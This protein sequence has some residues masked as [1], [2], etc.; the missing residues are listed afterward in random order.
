MTVL[1]QNDVTRLQ[2]FVITLNCVGISVRSQH[3]QDV[4]AVLFNTKLIALPSWSIYKVV[5][6]PSKQTPL[7]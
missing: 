2:L 3:A 1:L 6:F 7:P 4:D 5:S